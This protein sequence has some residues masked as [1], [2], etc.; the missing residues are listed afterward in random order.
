M[1][2][3]GAALGVTVG[4]EAGVVVTAPVLDT[5]PVPDVPPEDVDLTTVLLAVLIV[6][7]TELAVE[8]GSDEV[9]EG[10]FVLLATVLVLVS[11]L[12]EDEGEDEDD[13]VADSLPALTWPTLPF[14]SLI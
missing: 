11:A 7:L 4:V 10:D 1:A 14:P 6:V 8:V 2:L 9:V 3:R 5:A 13:V 12:D